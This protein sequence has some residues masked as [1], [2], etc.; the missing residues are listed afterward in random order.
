MVLRARW[1]G[2]H[3]MVEILAADC[4]GGRGRD[5]AGPD[6]REDPFSAFHA[7]LVLQGSEVF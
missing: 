2:I 3:Q 6:F 5:T 1:E 7:T 4:H